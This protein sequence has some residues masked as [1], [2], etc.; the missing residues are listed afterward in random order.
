MTQRHVLPGVAVAAL[1]AVMMAPVP[2]SGQ[3]AGESATPRT[4]W[5]HPNLQGYWTSSTYTPLERP[6]NLGDQAFLS[7]E[8]LAA[9]NEILTAEGSTR[10]G[11][12][13]FWPPGP[14]RNVSHGRS[15][16]RRTSTTT[17]RS[18]CASRSRGS[19]RPSARR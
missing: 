19:S 10:Y 4:P 18:G 12:A 2:A 17:T 6:E 8:E 15:R 14:K 11:R 13:A 16:R 9:A 5:G 3:S 7:D 1:A